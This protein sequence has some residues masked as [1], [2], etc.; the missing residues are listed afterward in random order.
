MVKKKYIIEKKM[1]LKKGD[2]KLIKLYIFDEK[3]TLFLKKL[4]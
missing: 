2:V 3:K 1:Y 4:A